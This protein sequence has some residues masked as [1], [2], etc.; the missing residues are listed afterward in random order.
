M[1]LVRDTGMGP[2]VAVVLP[3]FQRSVDEF[4]GAWWSRTSGRHENVC[5]EVHWYH[6][7][8]NEWHGRTFA[9]HLRAVEEHAQELQR[10]PMVVGEWSLALGRGAQPG[11]VSREEMCA[12][13]GRAQLAAYGQASHGW[14]FWNWCDANGTEWDWQQSHK[15]GYLPIGFDAALQQPGLPPPAAARGTY[16]EDPLEQ[17]L[18]APPADPRV[19]L[20]DTVYLRAFNGRYVD[21]DSK[22]GSHVRARYGDRG[23][24]QQFTLCPVSDHAITPVRTDSS[25]LRDGDR[26]SLLAH[27]GRY[28][29]LVDGAVMAEWTSV[30]EP[31]AFILR[32]DGAADVRHRTVVFLQSP[33]TGNVLAPNESDSQNQDAVVARWQHLGHWQR[34]VIEKPLCTAVTPHRPRRRSSFPGG[35]PAREGSPHSQRRSG[36]GAEQ[37]PSVVQRCANGLELLAQILLTPSRRRSVGTA[38]EPRPQTAVTPR[39]LKPHGS[40]CGLQRRA[41]VGGS[42][43]CA[44]SA[45]PRQRRASIGGS[46]DVG[47]PQQAVTRRGLQRR[48]SIGGAE[49]ISALPQAVTPRRRRSSVGAGLADPWA[50]SM[51]QAF[52]VLYYTVLYYTILYY[53][54]IRYTTLLHYSV[55]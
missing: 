48:A 43:D 27:T 28:L 7:F 51:P 20:G 41:S 11:R 16:K 45:T 29:G 40:G 31:C 53:T 26:V 25:G 46:E 37:K 3:V 22:E 13:F 14:F 10:Y 4:V 34:F 8:E 6:C 36:A 35:L 9:Q 12:L 32:T 44:P 52:A 21:V 50:A 55:L 15:A 23:K 17:V 1:G 33:V 47:A 38:E 42:E 2:R 18:D 19:R 24:W 39:Q 54:I 30:E 5:F 49:D